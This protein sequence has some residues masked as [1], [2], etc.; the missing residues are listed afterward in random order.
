MI[1]APN[2][3]PPL[4]GNRWLL[5]LAI[6]FIAA[7]CS[8]KV[9][10]VAVQ[11]VKTEPEKPV[12]KPVEKPKVVKAA[13]KVSSIA[14]LLPFGLDH[15]RPGSAAYTSVSLK[16]ADISLAFY[17]GFKLALD[18]LTGQG[19][20]YKLRI[21]DSKG[22]HAQ[23]HSLAI[24]PAIRASDLII[25]P[26]FPDDLKVFSDSYYNP[27][28]PIVSPLSPASPSSIKNGELIT[29]APPLE[30]HAWGAAQYIN[31]VLKPKKVFIIKS[32]FAEE[33]EYTVPFKKAIDSLSKK[34]IRVVQF[35]LVH[36]QL[37]TLFP[38]LSMTDQNIFI[39][40]STKQHFLTVALNALDTLNNTYPVTVFGH[41]GWANLS[42]LKAD[43][44]QRLDTHIT[45]ADHVDYKDENTIFFLKQYR[46]AYHTEP[47]AF[48]IKGFDEGL[49]LGK[50]LATGNLTNLAASDY[51]GLHNTFHFQKKEGLGWINTH[52]SIYKYANFE[53]QKEE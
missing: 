21:Y 23:A 29:M 5:F 41:P 47:T 27:R 24:N 10:P 51:D 35:T 20:N 4:S 42:Y 31:D 19:Y 3:R 52:I 14:L 15:L 1:S 43:L 37:N 2:R 38:Q 33:N 28:Q 50:L 7:A 40:P 6:T 44:L 32:G 34:H 36:G 48:A 39:V 9:R 8:P 13:P 12:V 18:S 16:E 26:V 30:Y 25:G 22:D 49:Y 45:L 46:Q 53:L 11:P 17:R